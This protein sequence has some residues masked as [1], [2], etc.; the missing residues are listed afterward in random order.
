MHDINHERRMVL[1][2]KNPDPNKLEIRVWQNPAA[3]G[4]R[5]IKCQGRE[6]RKKW[7]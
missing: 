3:L 4:G 7:P 2:E 5:L 1:W 6:G